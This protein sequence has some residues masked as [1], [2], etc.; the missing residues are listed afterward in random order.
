VLFLS[1]VL[2]VGWGVDKG[3]VEKKPYW[4]V[5]NQLS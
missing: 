2:L 3:L 4:K 5:N 1:A